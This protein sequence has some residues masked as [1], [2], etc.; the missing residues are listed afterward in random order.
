[1]PTPIDPLHP[2]L[3]A[4]AL[5]AALTREL[6]WLRIAARSYGTPTYQRLVAYSASRLHWTIRYQLRVG[7]KWVR[8]R[9]P[10]APSG[11]EPIDVDILW[12][13]E[14]SEAVLRAWAQVLRPEA[15]A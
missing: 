13:G 4:V 9:T 7:C 5:Q 2:M 12:T 10:P 8:F 1:M 6:D 15:Q 14:R 11:T 3:T